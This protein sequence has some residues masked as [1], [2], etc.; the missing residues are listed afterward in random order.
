MHS[1]PEDFYGAELRV[2]V[3][4]HIRPELK[5]NS[6]GKSRNFSSYH[7]GLPLIQPSLWEHL[8]STVDSSHPWDQ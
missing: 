7:S 6:L 5:F 3:V 1:F 2:C 4:G 8:I